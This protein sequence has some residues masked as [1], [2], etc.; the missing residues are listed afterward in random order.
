MRDYLIISL[1]VATGI[2]IFEALQ[3][4]L[5]AVAWRRFNLWLDKD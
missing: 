4:L 3:F 2:V 5:I 1:A